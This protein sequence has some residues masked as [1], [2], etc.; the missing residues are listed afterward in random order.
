MKET[1]TRNIRKLSL[2]PALC[3]ISGN[4]ITRRSSTDFISPS[5]HTLLFPFTPSVEKK[6][7]QTINIISKMTWLCGNT[8]LV[9]IILLF[10][11]YSSKN[12]LVERKDRSNAVNCFV[13]YGF[14]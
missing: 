12:K 14:F 9:S 6:T 8:N 4:P 2:V 10:L 3:C 11:H 7:K 5:A 1:N 13:L